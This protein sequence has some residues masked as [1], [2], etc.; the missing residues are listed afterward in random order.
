MLRKEP[1]TPIVLRETTLGR[2]WSCLV[3]L[4]V[5]E[6]EVVDFAAMESWR[7]AMFLSEA[8]EGTPEFVEGTAVS[9]AEV[10]WQAI[11]ETVGDA[12]RLADE[13]AEMIMDELS[14][15]PPKGG[16]MSLDRVFYSFEPHHLQPLLE[17]P[18][19]LAMAWM[20]GRAVTQSLDK[21]KKKYKERMN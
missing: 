1:D 13:R 21:L 18:P 12:I 11:T 4:G 2:Y 19:I 15:E 17:M 8:L 14:H 10:A 20:R 6:N 16:S 3:I 9:V 7:L 5:K